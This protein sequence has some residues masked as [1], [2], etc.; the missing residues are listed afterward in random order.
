MKKGFFAV[1]F[2]FI[3]FFI[4]FLFIEKGLCNDVNE[5]RQLV[6]KARLTL[7]NFY[8]ANEMETFRILAKKAKGFF[9]APQILK[10]AFLFGASGGSG[11]FIARDL[12]TSDFSY[13]AFYTLGEVSFGLQIGGE[14]AEVV[15]VIMSEKGV[16]ALLSN[17]VKLGVDVGIA[18][19]PV[20]AGVDASTANLSADIITFSKAKGLYGG[21]SLEGAFIKTRNDWNKVY[22]GNEVTSVDIIIKHKAKNPHA[23]PLIEMAQKIVSEK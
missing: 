7:E 2:V 21:L 1:I 15:M 19:G 20:G 8:L 3:L 14:S 16:S 17:S 13:P 23:K 18:I 10:G 5:T 4:N 12:K 22:Y 9:I 11:I 6:E